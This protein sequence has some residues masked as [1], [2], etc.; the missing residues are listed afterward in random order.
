MKRAFENSQIVLALVL[1][2]IVKMTKKDEAKRPPAKTM[3]PW[4]PWSPTED[5]EENTDLNVK[6]GKK[7]ASFRDEETKFDKF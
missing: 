6:S 7:N 3:V 4:L 2:G 1:S 5:I